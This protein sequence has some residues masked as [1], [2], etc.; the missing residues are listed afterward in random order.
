MPKMPKS[1]GEL[2]PENWL[3]GSLKKFVAA[4]IIIALWILLYL[5]RLTKTVSCA[6]KVLCGPK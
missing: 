1:A 5:S 3:N 6:L 2:R 4:L